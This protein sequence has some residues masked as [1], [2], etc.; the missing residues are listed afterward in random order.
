MRPSDVRS[1]I[2]SQINRK[3]TI[4]ELRKVQEIID[5]YEKAANQAL[6]EIQSSLIT[7]LSDDGSVSV[8]M[9]CQWVPK[10]IYGTK[11]KELIS[12]ALSEII[13]KALNNTVDKT[14]SV[15]NEYNKNMQQQG[16]ELL[17]EIKTALNITTYNEFNTPISLEQTESKL[18]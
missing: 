8:E 17:L 9:D 16:T 4:E 1:Y 10:R 6:Q 3:P 15:L 18:N 13:C 11:E 12:P 7:G 14:N 5:R 2:I